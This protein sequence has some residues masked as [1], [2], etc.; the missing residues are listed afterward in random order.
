V[1]L[2]AQVL[3][4]LVLL[5]Q[6]QPL[7]LNVYITSNVDAKLLHYPVNERSVLSGF[8]ETFFELPA[9]DTR[10]REPRTRELS[11]PKQLVRARR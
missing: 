10:A 7:K 4:R 3:S 2:I 5:N 6:G 8:C 1:A 9:S 11:L